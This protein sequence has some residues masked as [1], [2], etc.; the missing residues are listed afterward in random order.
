MENSEKFWNKL[1]KNYDKKA[2]DKAYEQ[3]LNRT[4]KY[5]CEDAEVI[6]FACATGLYAIAFAEDVKAIQAFDTSSEMIAL[7]KKK[8]NGIENI[9][10]SQTTL[11]DEKFVTGGFDI[12]FA[13]NI[14]LYFEDMS[15]IL[16]KMHKLL[17]PKGRIITATACLK[18]KRTFIGIFSGCV[19][20][21]LKKINIL[22]FLKFVTIKELKKEITTAEFEILEA[23]ILIDKPAT[24]YYIVAQKK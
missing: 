1:S 21:L 10:F 6:D 15:P 20:Y 11:F 7:A 19:I 5:L 2:K 16:N 12:I 3:I 22:P 14:L 18:E 13:F 4:R 24:E 8:A 17:K 9:S 23:D